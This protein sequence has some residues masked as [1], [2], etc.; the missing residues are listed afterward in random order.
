[1]LAGAGGSY[2]QQRVSVGRRADGHDVH[3]RRSQEIGGVG[4]GA[5][6][7]ALRRLLTAS[8]IHVSHGH[9]PQVGHGRVHV[10]TEAAEASIADQSQTQ[11]FHFLQTATEGTEDTERFFLNVSVSSVDYDPV[12]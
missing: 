9:H 8:R 6:A 1:M 2:A 5:R 4:V 10:Q 7:I 3:V 11:R 12:L